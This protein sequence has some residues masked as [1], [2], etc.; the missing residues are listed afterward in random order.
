MSVYRPAW[1]DDL[2]AE[3]VHTPITTDARTLQNPGTYL[4][5]PTGR[6]FAEV[7]EYGQADFDAAIGEN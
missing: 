6:I 4:G 2:L 7:I 1:M 5:W 3:L